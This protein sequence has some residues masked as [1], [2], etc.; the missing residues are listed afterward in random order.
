M[1]KTNFVLPNTR[2]CNVVWFRNGVRTETTIPTPETNTG[3]VNKMFEY[4]VGASEIRAVKPHY[5]PFSNPVLA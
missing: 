5:E 1:T 2:L 4:K 3:L